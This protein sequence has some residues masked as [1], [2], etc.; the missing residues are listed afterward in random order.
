MPRGNRSPDVAAMQAGGR[1]ARA[2]NAY[3]DAIAEPA[4]FRRGI[5]PA[6]Q[7]ERVENHLAREGLRPSE[8]VVLIQKRMD[9][10]AQQTPEVDL[11]ALTE[12]FVKYAGSYSERHGISY[13][14]WRTMGV[15]AS[16][17]KR[18]GLRRSRLA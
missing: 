18:L 17:V 7:L 10:Q 2:I 1:E 3:L 15:P 6:K 12:D 9:L 11:E 16:V 4:P 13:G 14:A 8:R 5:T